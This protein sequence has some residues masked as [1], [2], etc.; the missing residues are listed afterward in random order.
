MLGKKTFVWG[1]LV[2]LYP[3]TQV[4]AD[5]SELFLKLMSLGLFSEEA[6]SFNCHPTCGRCPGVSMFARLGRTPVH[7][8]VAAAMLSVQ[9]LWEKVMGQS[10]KSP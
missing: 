6:E 10:C 8:T 4:S 9:H 7:W 1:C 2:H 3:R 5:I